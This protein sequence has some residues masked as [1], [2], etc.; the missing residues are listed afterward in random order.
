LEKDSEQRVFGRSKAKQ[1]KARQGKARQG[2]ARQGKAKQ[3]KAKQ[4]KQTNKK[5]PKTILKSNH[6]YKPFLVCEDS[7]RQLSLCSA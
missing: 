6:R 3:S 7:S 5:K 1:G 4:N 2:K